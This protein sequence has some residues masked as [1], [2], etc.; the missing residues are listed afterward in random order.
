[1]LN[2]SLLMAPAPS[3]G[4]QGSALPSI[5]MLVGIFVVFYFFYDSSPI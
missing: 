5:L 4:Q 3:G 1:M 2:Y